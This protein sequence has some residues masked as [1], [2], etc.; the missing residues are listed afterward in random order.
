M[1]D[2]PAASIP[3]LPP[4][5]PMPTWVG[6][7]SEEARR[8]VLYLL[9]HSALEP[10]LRS[11]WVVDVAMSGVEDG[12]APLLPDAIS[13]EIAPGDPADAHRVFERLDAD[14]PA[15]LLRNVLQRV[16]DYRRFLGA[17]FDRL[18][19]EGYLLV[20]VPHQ[21]LYERKLQLPSRYQRSHLRLYSPATLL[22][23]IEEALDPCRYR[24]RLLADHDSGFDYT[25]PL[26]AVP[27]G[28]HDIVL[29]LQK[30]APPPWREAMERDESQSAAYTA[31]STYLPPYP[32]EPSAGAYRL[33]VPDDRGIGSLIVLK[34]DHRG[35]FMMA[36]PAFRILRQAFA[37]AA[38][39]LVCGSWNRREAESLDLFDRVAAFDFFPEDGSAGARAIPLDELCD[40]FA[41]TVAGDSWD[42][43]VDLRLYEDTRRLLQK[44]AARHKAG[45][46]PYDAFPWLTI[47]FGLLVS[48][49]DGRAEQRFVP[50]SRFHTQRGEHQ[51]FA[52]SFA[53]EP[54][55]P[56]DTALIYGPY[57]RLRPGYYEL[58]IL[59]ELKA[60]AAALSY[61]LTADHGQ[62]ILAAGPL[63]VERDRH[64]RIA[65]RLTERVEA[66][67]L[68]LAAARPGPLPAFRFLGLRYR[69]RGA[70][71]GMHQ[72]EA[73]SLLADLVV[74]R[75]HYPYAVERR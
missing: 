33:I 67:E 55:F 2:T 24:V 20:I 23:E 44:I 70:I 41:E 43:A 38:I 53:E 63:C 51:G 35:D 65:M 8:L 34:L 73:M 13:V 47:P 52:V 54:A 39:T 22:A 57:E 69:H 74:Q 61:Q 5:E 66:F 62:R 75:L 58:E 30:L 28:G 12:L 72:R 6:L 60:E 17:A 26:D 11:P 18:A 48:T 56:A 42:V 40:R 32:T 29:C 68:R 19:V 36:T 37:G 1:P 64:P 15:I 59:L 46:D 31:P 3:D 7:L 25:A 16:P 27:P 71:V 45:F 21:F 14:Q 10:A 50:A 9:S 49:V 4:P